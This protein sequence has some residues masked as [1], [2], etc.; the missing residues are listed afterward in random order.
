MDQGAAEKGYKKEQIISLQPNSL[1]SL[2]SS[3]IFIQDLPPHSSPWSTV[4]T[5][6]S[7]TL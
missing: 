7:L 4:K 3:L 2:L 5:I 6:F 1:I